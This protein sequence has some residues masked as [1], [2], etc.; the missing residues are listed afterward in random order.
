M[1]PIVRIF[2]GINLASDFLMVVSDFESG[3]NV[4][5]TESWTL[6]IYVVFFQIHLLHTFC[7]ASDFENITG[8]SSSWN[9]VLVPFFVNNWFSEMAMTSLRFVFANLETKIFDFPF[10]DKIS[11]VHVLPCLNPVRVLLAASV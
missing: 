8:V 10:R 11:H 7:G 6:P 9:L 4:P 5:G 1:V 2:Y 3:G